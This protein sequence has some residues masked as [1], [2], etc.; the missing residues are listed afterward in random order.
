M[1]KLLIPIFFALLLGCEEAEQ[2]VETPAEV[3]RAIPSRVYSGA[4]VL[5]RD[6]IHILSNKKIG[7]V[8][9]HTSLVFGKTHLVDTL[10]SKGVNV[11]KVF[12]PEHGFRGD[13]DAG[14]HIAN[15]TDPATGLPIVSLHG[16]NKKP[17]QNQLAGLDLIVFDIQDV[18]ARFY[19]YIS[20]LTY[21]MDACA[22]A[23]IPVLILDRPNPN[24]WYVDGPVLNKKYQSFIGMHEIPAIHGMTIGE[25]ALMILG[26]GWY[27]SEKACQVDVIKAAGYKHAMRWEETG[28]SW[29]APS[30]NL[31]TLR[32]AS[33][34]PALCWFEPTPVSIGRGTD[35]AFTIIGAPWLTRR[36]AMEGE[37]FD[38]PWTTFTPRSLPGKST[39]PKFQDKDCGGYRITEV[40]PSSR[41][42]FMLGIQLFKNAYSDYGKK[43]DFFKKNFERWPGNKNFKAAIIAEK[44]AGDIYESWKPEV[45]AFKQKRKNYLLYR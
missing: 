45:E 14:A 19:T 9:N 29:V 27:E 39:Y 37:S 42:L 20:T 30:P 7:I 33:L 25:Y 10:I 28:L 40:P 31:A 32:A 44:S 24:G 13:A 8:G 3:Q 12:S 16:K 6:S 15:S 26:E 5:V 23:G 4:E 21:V 18:G 34:Y 11:K 43:P 35:S 41:R 22:E 38:L 17:P 2:P 36:K 1:I